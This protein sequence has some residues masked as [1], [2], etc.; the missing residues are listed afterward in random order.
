MAEDDKSEPAKPS[1]PSYWGFTMDEWSGADAIRAL[2]DTIKGFI[3]QSGRQTTKLIVLT[4]AI[5]GLTVAM[6]FG[7][8]IQIFIAWPK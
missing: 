3:D 4:W 5:V 8:A 1:P 6:L 7:L 2:H